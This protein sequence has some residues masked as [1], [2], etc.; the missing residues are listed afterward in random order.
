MMSFLTLAATE[1]LIEGW[2]TEEQHSA[3]ITSLFANVNKQTWIMHN[4]TQDHKQLYTL[5]DH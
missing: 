5:T 1:L 2:D 4:H 3:H